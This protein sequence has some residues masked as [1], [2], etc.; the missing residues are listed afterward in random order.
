MSKRFNREA[1]THRLMRAPYFSE[2]RLR[3]EL[4]GGSVRCAVR[5]ECAA[6]RRPG[7]VGAYIVDRRWRCT[8]TEH[9]P[10]HPALLPAV[11]G[12]A[13]LP[14]QVIWSPKQYNISPGAEVRL[15]NQL[16]R[17]EK[18][19][20][21]NLAFADP[22]YCRFSTSADPYKL[23]NTCLSVLVPIRAEGESS[24]FEIAG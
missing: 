20:L 2:H 10:H 7:R 23:S 12:V 4:Q 5:R 21:C 1:H 6:P 13:R 19:I 17:F 22:V 11:R 14:P 24:C 3:L 18:R 16:I 15:T 8:R 9:R